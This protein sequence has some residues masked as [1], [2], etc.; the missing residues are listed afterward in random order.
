MKRRGQW[1]NYSAPGLYMIT[2]VVNDRKPL[3]GTLI[4]NN[5]Q[6][7]IEHSLL[8][9]TIINE[10][11]NKISHF[12]PMVEVWR[13]CIMPDHIHMILNVKTAMPAGKHLG[14]VV[15]GF[16]TGCT[17][18]LWRIMDEGNP[19][20]TQPGCPQQM[21]Q[22]SGRITEKPLPRMKH[23][24][25]VAENIQQ[26]SQHGGH[27]AENTQQ[28]L[29][30]GGRVAEG[31]PSAMKPLL[32]ENGYNDKILTG[33]DQLNRWKRYLDDNP[34]R[35]ML[36][37]K[38]PDLFSVMHNVVIAGRSCMSVGN[39]FLLDIPEKTAVIVHR[40]N[41]R[42]EFL[43]MREQWLATGENGGV[44]VSAAIAPREKEVLREA[45]NRGYK[46][47]LLRENGFPQLYKPSGEKFEACTRGQLLEISPWQY[48][49]ERQQISRSQCLE[50]NKLAQLIAQE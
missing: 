5:G 38:H 33:R 24:G 1:H 31:S 49:M 19:S 41:T 44:L 32:F 23:G 40:R 9:K 28:M 20:P 35:L 43:A 37:R 16:K 8:G 22:H 27:V 14:N 21:Q 13:L 11:I 39:R 45:M 29:Q 48:H 4:E 10:E 30:H 3:L 7:Y 2:L 15:Y 46:I 25:R 47:I 36:K 34:R 12:Y 50:L 17:R 26:I 18:A 6:A 42:D